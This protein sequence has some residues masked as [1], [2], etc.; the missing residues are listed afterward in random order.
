LIK[1]TLAT[2]FPAE[3]SAEWSDCELYASLDLLH[4]SQ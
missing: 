1:S 3:L 4:L 2:L